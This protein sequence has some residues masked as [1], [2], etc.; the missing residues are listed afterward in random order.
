MIPERSFFVRKMEFM[1]FLTGA[2]TK[3]Y[4]LVDS[5]DYDFIRQYVWHLASGVA[6]TRVEKNKCIF[7]HR[8]IAARMGIEGKLISHKNGNRLDNRRS[9]IIAT[10]R[11]TSALIS[12]KISKNSSSKLRGVTWHKETEKWCATIFING[13]HHYLGLFNNT[14][15]AVEARE[16][17]LNE[18]L[19]AN[20]IL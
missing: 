17:C 20:G 14:R 4:M 3:S 18:Y 6:R 13:V 5:E 2:H 11:S 8:L 19:S 15:E 10:N 16:R 12:K 7:A 9:N 1:I